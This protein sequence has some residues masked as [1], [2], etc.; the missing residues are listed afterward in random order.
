MEVIG[1]TQ[2]LAHEI[3]Y[4]GKYGMVWCNYPE[5]QPFPAT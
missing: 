3:S 4:F 2:E 1:K 5:E